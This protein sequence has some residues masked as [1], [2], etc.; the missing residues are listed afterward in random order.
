[1]PALALAGD[2]RR[3]EADRED[4]VEADRDRMDEADRH[5]AAQRE[6]VAAAELGELLDGS[7]PLAKMS[8]KAEPNES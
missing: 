1:M 2:G 5:R 7:A 8:L 4:E 3:R 6:D